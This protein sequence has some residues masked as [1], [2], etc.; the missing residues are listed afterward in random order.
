[1]RRAVAIA[2]LLLAG[3]CTDHPAADGDPAG[4]PVS[5]T[6][7]VGDTTQVLAGLGD[8]A[9]EVDLAGYRGEPLLVNF[10]ASTCVPCVQ[11]MPAI[12]AAF[13]AA[14]GAFEVVGVAVND[15]VDAALDLV[16]RTGVTWDLANDPDGTFV[17]AAG[18][19][20]LPTTVFV[21]ADGNIV[22][23]HVGAM[24]SG[25]L[26]SLLRDNFGIDVPA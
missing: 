19:L 9:P 18:G 20:Y 5:G 6:A 4:E 3:A 15:R 1:M 21:D 26:A 16:R 25:D 8:G 2:V 17:R 11:E 12:Q 13:E 24:S 14:G 10:F 7:A 22:D 23:T